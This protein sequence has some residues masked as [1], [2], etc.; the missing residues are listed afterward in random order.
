MEIVK[1]IYINSPKT[2]GHGLSLSYRLSSIEDSLQA[3]KE[4]DAYESIDR[5]GEQDFPSSSCMQ[6]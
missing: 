2:P 5:L 4:A 6:E 3:L 1:L